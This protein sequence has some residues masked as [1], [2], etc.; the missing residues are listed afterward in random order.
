MGNFM[1][2]YQ[3]NPKLSHYDQQPADREKLIP[4]VKE[5]LR[6]NMW[7]Y[8]KYNGNWYT[9]EEFGTKYKRTQLNNYEMA[10]M[11]ENMIIRDPRTGNT[12]YHKEIEKR[13]ET[14][15]KEINEL[16]TKGEAF[17]HKVVSYYQQKR[18]EH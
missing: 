11:L 1:K 3:D 17:L 8:N 14:F 16:R 4:I 6:L 5:A 2:G 18:S 7:L 15:H 9:P 13:I 12:A 10:R